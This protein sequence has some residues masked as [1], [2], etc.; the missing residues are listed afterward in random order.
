MT[1]GV[2]VRFAPSPTGH[3]HVGS[4]HTALF[5]WL[6]ARHHGGRF[7][8]RIE[9]T[10]RSRS[11]E[12][13]IGSILD[14]LRWLALDW[15]EGPPTPGYR[16]TERLD[17]YREHAARLLGRGRAYY[18]DCP[19][20]QLEGERKA[21]EARKETFRYSGRCR[22]RG[23]GAGALRLRMPD[24]GATVVPDLINGPV[25]FDHRQL[26]DWIL[27]RT[28]G[29][30]T[31]NFCVVVDDV[32]MRISHVIRGNDHLSNT[33]K[34]V[35]CY[36]ALDYQAPAFAHVSMILGPDRARLS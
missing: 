31:Y 21:A 11:T 16:Q 35:L 1:D 15:D 5:N 36:E 9:D 33:P 22:E 24:E 20:A 13:N 32:T 4:A 19:P 26:D 10:D 34:Q 17:L 18:C 28:D 3:L 6:Y 2:R 25:V 8:L 23:L 14:A 12:E 7:I 29:T 30:P 27:V